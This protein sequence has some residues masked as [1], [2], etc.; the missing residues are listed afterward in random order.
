MTG[1]PGNSRSTSELGHPREGVL[2]RA[3]PPGMENEMQEKAKSNSTI[4]HKMVD[5][6]I[7]FTV[8][9]AGVLTFD[10]DKVSA[11]NCAR[12]MIHGFV[13]R[14]S[15]RAAISRNPENG[16]PATP[17][18]KLTR[19]QQMAEHLMS[20]AREWG[21]KAAAA[22]GMDAGLIVRAMLRA[23]LGATVEA[24]E[25][26]L[27]KTQAKRSI[28]RTAALKLWAGTDKVIRAM[29][30]LKAE[31]APKGAEDLLAEM[32]AEEEEEGEGQD[33]PGDDAAPL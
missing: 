30:E 33:E 25:G 23:G 11:E 7:E 18:D 13:Q 26:L 24:V 5:G 4:T 31:A 12:A 17:Q 16:Q 1:G 21:L 14:I 19:M 8:L 29:A 20:G 22:P 2:G 15:D 10:P 9:G 27:T 28:D 6:K 32:M 3:I